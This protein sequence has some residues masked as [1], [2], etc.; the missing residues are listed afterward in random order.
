MNIH[1]EYPLEYPPLKIDPFEH[2]IGERSRSPRSFISN[3]LLSPFKYMDNPII[4][5]RPDQPLVA[6]SEALTA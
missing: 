2:K 6:L 1:F 4:N 5:P 3:C